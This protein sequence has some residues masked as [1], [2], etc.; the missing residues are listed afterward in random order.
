MRLLGTALEQTSESVVITDARLDLPGPAI[1]FVNSAY[2]RMTGFTAED[3]IGKTPRILQ[4]PRTD[5]AVLSR[6]RRNLEQGEHFA[7]ETISCRKDRTEFDL[8]WR[9]APVRNAGGEITHFVGVQ[10]DITERKTRERE[11][12]RANRALR[13]LSASNEALIRAEAEPELLER[14]CRIA[15]ETGGYRMAWVGYAQDDEACS[16]KPMAYAGAEEGYFSEIKISWNENDPL[17]QGPA[18]QVIRTGRALVC[19][20]ILDDAMFAP[21]HAAAG[22]RGF[23]GVT[24]LPLIEGQR[25]FGLLGLYSSEVNDAGAGEVKLL[26]ELAANLAFGIVHL[27]DRLDQQRLQAAVLQVAAG[28][29]SASG[30]EFFEH[31]SRHMADAVGAQAGVVA[32]INAGQPLSASTIVAVVDGKVAANFDYLIEGSPCANLATTDSFVVEQ[33]AAEQFPQARG[34]AELRAQAY[35]GRRLDDSAGRPL[36]ILFVVFREALKDVGFV[37]STLQI[38]AA[39]A[40][41]E[42]ERQQTDRQVREQAALIDES[43]DAIVVRDLDNRITFWSKGAERLYGWSAGQARGSSLQEL[44]SADPATYAEADRTVRETGEWSG[45][46]Q[47]EARSSTVLTLNGR[48]TLLHGNDGKPISILSVDSDITDQKKIAEQYFRAQRMESIGTLAGGIAHDLNNVLSPIIMSLELL[49]ARFPD[50]GSAELLSIVSASAQRGADMVRQVL[51]FARGVEGRRMELQLRHLIKEVE[52]IANDTFLKNIQVRSIIPN[53]LWTVVGDPTQIHQ[54]LLNLCVNARDAM[55]YGGNLVISAGNRILDAQ[56]AALNL[57]AT[58]GPYVFLQVEDSGTG[59]PPAVIEKIFD[60]FFTTKEAG[61][62]TGLGLSTSLAIVKS[63]GGFFRVDSEP[64]KGTKFQ[65]YLSAQP[66]ATQDAAERIAAELPRGHGELIL[67]VDDEASVRAITQATLEAFGYRV[68]LA[69]DGAEAVALYASCRSEIA[70]VLTDMTMPVM[71]GLATIQVLKN[72]DP[73]V[74]IVASS[75]LAVS[76][77]VTRACGLDMKHFIAK[78]YT[79][80]MVLKVLREIL[81]PES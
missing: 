73:A 10:R 72:L 8:E 50:A 31:L 5:R 25:T 15:A 59:M 23:R 75:G 44:L 16:I 56:Y 62:G 40:A 66:A 54:V 14:I 22:R 28:V 32:K 43:R 65:V 55:P 51:S 9:V 3:S 36:G 57:E 12:N 37:S 20:D 52:Q 77:E 11:L 39:R 58:A 48:W 53:D 33:R 47:M 35:V 41:S 76:A 38:F 17:G 13:L 61:K 42:L 7:G 63:H 78:P 4:G 49:S 81:A 69:C 60:P 71:D 34:L 80:E 46:I 18:G 27:R 26:Q 2:T 1:V 70:V 79:A 64:G 24:L 29:S 67:V 6:L 74:R 30:T 68:L 21:W 19:L 45:E